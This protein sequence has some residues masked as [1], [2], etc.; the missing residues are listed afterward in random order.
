MITIP[1]LTIVDLSLNAYSYQDAEINILHSYLTEQTFAFT[2][3]EIPNDIEGRKGR[4]FK[5]AGQP[6]INRLQNSLGVN[7][8]NIGPTTTT[9]F[10]ATAGTPYRCIRLKHMPWENGCEDITA[11]DD[12]SAFIKCSLVANKN[13]W[14]GADSE[15]GTCQDQR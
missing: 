4:S 10:L 3:Q 9:T 8:T 1:I 2:S 5:I 14:F 15:H 13:N 11:S 6:Q 7:F 12:H